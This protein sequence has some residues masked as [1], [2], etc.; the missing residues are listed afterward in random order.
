[1]VRIKGVK[2]IKDS[3]KSR[4]YVDD[5]SEAPE[6]A[7]VQQGEQGGYFYDTSSEDEENGGNQEETELNTEVE[8]GDLEEGDA[9]TIEDGGETF[10][11]AVTESSIAA[12]KVELENGE[13]LSFDPLSISNPL[14]EYDSFG[15]V[16]SVSGEEETE[17]ERD[18]EEIMQERMEELPV[19]PDPPSDDDP[20]QGVELDSE[21]FN[22]GESGNVSSEDVESAAASFADGEVMGI[23][24][25]MRE[26]EGDEYG[27]F[28]DETD[29]GWYDGENSKFPHTDV[30][31]NTEDFSNLQHQIHQ[32]FWDTSRAS[33]FGSARVDDVKDYA[34]TMEEEE[35]EFPV[36]FLI[37]NEEGGVTDN[38]EGRHRALAAMEAGYDE[39]PVRILVEPGK[40]GKGRIYVDDASEAPDDVNVEEGERGDLYYEAHNGQEGGYR[41]GQ[42]S[43]A[44]KGD[45]V[46][47][48][49]QDGEVQ[50]GEYVDQDGGME[51]V[52]AI[53]EDDDGNTH[54]ASFDHLEIVDPV[55]PEEGEEVPWMELRKGDKVSYL[56]SWGEEIPATVI[57][58]DTEGTIHAREEKNG[59]KMEIPPG[60]RFLRS[61]ESDDR[62]VEEYAMGLSVEDASADFESKAV[63]YISDRVAGNAKEE[64]TARDVIDHVTTVRD[65]SDKN[66]FSPL[67][68]GI[69]FKED[70]KDSTIAHEYAHALADSYGYDTANGTDNP[71]NLFAMFGVEN[72]LPLQFGEGFKDNVSAVL[73][74]LDEKREDFDMDEGIQESIEE[75]FSNDNTIERDDF[76]LQQQDEDADV[77]EEIETL[78]EEVNNSWDFIMD[79]VEDDD[80]QR[81]ELRTPMRPYVATNC[82][83]MIA[84]TQQILQ[85]SD[86]NEAHARTLYEFHPD[87][88]NAYLDVYDP[89]DEAKQAIN[90]FHN[91]MGLD[92]FDS[93]PFPDLEEDEQ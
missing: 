62:T 60:S 74:H 42:Y 70:C 22:G 69:Q 44:I 61:E 43:N 51:G 35:G 68:K 3:Q 90:D 63:Q 9:I 78:M 80:L 89:S 91:N 14:D 66:A 26:M 7:D 1:M 47:F 28:D 58:I 64:S 79:F 18:A 15:R 45:R 11:G 10:N 2:V 32:Q 84:G 17:P 8:L 12:V 33:H 37:V 40:V 57:T 24:V 48:V 49:N 50:E 55:M 71:I 25:E 82:H 34:E 92:T 56:A 29:I 41:Y 59:N 4:E 39:I 19:V 76:K 81:A 67:T 38:Q 75:N 52:H 65:D 21:D 85:S 36:P 86:G 53:I 93:T 88:L 46:R 13:E 5:P 16:E 6:W 83:E 77:P 87:L 30:M 23:N 27:P 54:Y 31:I 20:A 72:Q 73:K